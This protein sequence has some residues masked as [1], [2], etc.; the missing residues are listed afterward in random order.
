MKFD[1]AEVTLIIWVVAAAVKANDLFV[2]VALGVVLWVAMPLLERRSVR[3]KKE[4]VVHRRKRV[5]RLQ[6]R[7][8]GPNESAQQVAEDGTPK[9]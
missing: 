9:R 8:S 3:K 1:F 2:T 5:G 4:T 6:S 7:P